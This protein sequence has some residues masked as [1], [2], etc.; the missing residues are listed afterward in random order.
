[1]FNKHGWAR[2]RSVCEC[3]CG[4]IFMADTHKIQSGHTKSCGCF[5]KQFPANFRHGHSPDGKATSTYISWAGMIDRC[6]R[7]KN[8]RYNRYGGRGITVCERWRTSFTNFLADMGPGKKGWTIHRV[9]NDGNYCM[10]NLVWALPTFQA[11]H[12]SRNR[13][14]TVNGFTGCVSELC[15]RFGISSS[16]VYARLNRYKW[17]VED[18]FNVP[19]LTR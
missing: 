10:E 19:T 7:K 3:Y 1:M 9:D 16:V 13:I 18:A 14:V 8:K 17:S 5:Q 6:Y 15:E 4:N 2:R 11:R 12:T